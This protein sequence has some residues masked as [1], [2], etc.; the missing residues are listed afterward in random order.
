[1]N[2]FFRLRFI[3]KNCDRIISLHKMSILEKEITIINFKT[4]GIW[5]TFLL[6]QF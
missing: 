4:K 3:V 2:S 1:M 5:S 6:F